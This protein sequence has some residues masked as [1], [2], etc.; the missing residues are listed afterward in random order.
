MK[1][2]AM[3]KLYDFSQT[4]KS[5]DITSISD[6]LVLGQ[7]VE[8][9]KNLTTKKEY[10][11]T[12]GLLEKKIKQHAISPPFD[13]DGLITAREANFEE[14]EKRNKELNLL[15]AIN[16]LRLRPSEINLSTFYQDYGAEL[17]A[18]IVYDKCNMSSFYRKQ[19]NDRT[20][21][22]DAQRA[23][24][25]AF[26]RECQGF[27][28]NSMRKLLSDP[29]P[30]FPF[31]APFGHLKERYIVISGAKEAFRIYEISNST[32][33]VKDFVVSFRNAIRNH[34]NPL[35]D[36]YQKVE[37]SARLCVGSVS[38]IEESVSRGFR[39]NQ[40]LLEIAKDSKMD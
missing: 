4:L 3:T 31:N 13:E 5:E 37:D 11:K 18:S 36:Q 40:H 23:W 6:F 24:T 32:T 9:L 15:F 17:A 26:G 10:A 33:S 35:V 8:T 25:I 29:A 22:T 39:D 28:R 30:S 16:E 7:V 14:W 27:V 21:R 34:S 19:Y 38:S 20:S 1:A 2:K 12:K